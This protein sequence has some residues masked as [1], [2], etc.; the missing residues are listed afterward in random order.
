MTLLETHYTVV[1]KVAE[2]ISKVFRWTANGLIN[3]ATASRSV[4]IRFMD[5]AIHAL[6]KKRAAMEKRLSVDDP[7]LR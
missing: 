6:T 4:G 5:I 1:A 3:M 2:G 7:E